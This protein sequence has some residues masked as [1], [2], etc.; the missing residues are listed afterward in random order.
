MCSN[1][2]A[3]IHIDLCLVCIK[4]AQFNAFLLL[5]VENERFRVVTNKQSTNGSIVVALLRMVI[6]TGN[7]ELLQ[8]R[9]SGA[10]RILQRSGFLRQSAIMHVWSSFVCSQWVH[11]VSGTLNF[12]TFGNIPFFAFAL[13]CKKKKETRAK[14]WVYHGRML[15]EGNQSAR[16]R[17]KFSFQQWSEECF[18]WSC[19]CVFNTWEIY[20][21]EGLICVFP[22]IH[23]ISPPQQ[24]ASQPSPSATKKKAENSKMNNKHFQTHNARHRLKPFLAC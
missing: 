12:I 23:I 10:R 3:A 20:L 22:W 19:C 6:E 11:C 24:P 9:S 13:S 17:R 21:R 7:V 15:L 5:S 16:N 1:V 8:L 14:S 18:K 2:A 4:L